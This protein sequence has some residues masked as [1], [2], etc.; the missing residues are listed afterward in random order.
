MPRVTKERTGRRE[1]KEDE[2]SMGI[3]PHEGR[4]TKVLQDAVFQSTFKAMVGKTKRWRPSDGEPEH[5]WPAIIVDHPKLRHKTLVTCVGDEN[6]GY[7][8]TLFLPLEDDSAVG[9][10]RKELRTST[11]KFPMVWRPRS[12]Q[13]EEVGFAAR[14]EDERPL[15]LEQDRGI[16]VILFP[17]LNRMVV[18]EL[19]EDAPDELGYMISW[20]VLSGPAW[21]NT[22]LFLWAG[23]EVISVPFVGGTAH[24]MMLDSAGEQFPLVRFTESHPQ[25]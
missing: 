20:N 18:L 11:A 16:G 3:S 8:D 19:E 7:A 2:K 4:R 6:G 5:G 23:L 21:E 14:S 22:D 13:S 1:A 9:R 12:K 15:L 25:K 10:P 17:E 24:A